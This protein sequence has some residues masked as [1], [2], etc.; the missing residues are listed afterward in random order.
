MKNADRTLENLTDRY[1][2]ELSEIKALRNNILSEAKEQAR[3]IVAGAN[4]QIEQTIREIR[5]AQ[6]EKEKT[7]EARAKVTELQ[8]T[9]SEEEPAGASDDLIE[10]KMQQILER[11]Q[12]QQQKREERARRA[13]EEP[14]K[15]AV[16]APEKPEPL[17]VGDKVRIKESDMV[18]EIIQI[19][20]KKASVAVGGLTTKVDIGKVERISAK[21][22]KEAAKTTAP[23][24]ATSGGVA[25][26]GM[27]SISERKMHFSPQIDVRGERLES[28]LNIVTRFIDDAPMIGISQVKILHGKGTGVL[29]EE[30]RKY[31]KATAGVIAVHDEALEMGGAGITVV[32]LA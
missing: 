15:P 26:K 28:A 11:R 3:E 30:L 5:E 22:Y 20:T 19:S 10:R 27:E 9:L 32:E 2:K 4:R 17:K 16:K 14:P 1:E 24:K 21:E 25:V 7:K 12:R 31:L 6:A 8:Q 29:R 13:G 23:R 18:G